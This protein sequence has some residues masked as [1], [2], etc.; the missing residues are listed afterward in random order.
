MTEELGLRLDGPAPLRAALM[1]FSAFVIVGLV[2]LVPLFFSAQLSA[3]A[4]FQISA[5]ATGITFFSIGL[6]KGHIVH[7][8]LMKSSAGT[9]LLG[10]GA[11]VLAY[12]VGVWLRGLAG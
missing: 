3:S 4:T 6:L 11:A 5:V 1:T 2:P 9:L 10:G 8:P 12:V 7:H